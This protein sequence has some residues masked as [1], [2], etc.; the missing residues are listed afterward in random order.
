[1]S[2]KKSDLLGE[3]FSTASSK[4]KKLIMFDLIQKLELDTCYRCSL[5][6]EN[7]ETLSVEH[8]VSWQS[9]DDPVQSFYD[10]DKIAFSHLKCNIS[11]ERVKTHPS[12]EVYRHAKYANHYKKNREAIL[13]RKREMR[14][15]GRWT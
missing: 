11:A 10:L 6:I 14:K 13:K 3:N 9:A 4:L 2:K 12:P 7:V 5:K 15:L 1:M 8:T